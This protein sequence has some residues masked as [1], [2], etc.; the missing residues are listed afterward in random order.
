[1]AGIGGAPVDS[2]ARYGRVQY[3][4]GLYYFYLFLVEMHGQGRGTV[5]RFEILQ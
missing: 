4:G 5:P 3:W 2:R 1:M